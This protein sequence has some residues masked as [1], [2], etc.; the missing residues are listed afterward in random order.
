MA[1]KKYAAV[2]VPTNLRDAIKAEAN[3]NGRT[4]IGDLKIKYNYN[5]QST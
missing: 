4:M 2:F 5:G 3:K 1:D